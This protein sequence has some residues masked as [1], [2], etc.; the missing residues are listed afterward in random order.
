MRGTP[1]A[2]AALVDLLATGVEPL[3]VSERSGTAEFHY[4]FTL[5]I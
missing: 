2:N 1:A 3:C 5:L 4:R